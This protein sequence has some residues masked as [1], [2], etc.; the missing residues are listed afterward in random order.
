MNL[1]KYTLLTGITIS[2]SEKISVEA[3][4]KRTRRALETMLGF[5][6]SKSETNTNFYN[7]VGKSKLD[8]FCPNVST[9]NLLPP[10]EIVNSYRL[11]SYHKEDRY[12]FIDPFT[13]VNKVKLVFIR[14]GEPEESGITIKT[15]ADDEIR[16]QMGRDGIA[17]YLQHC[18]NY[19][20][21]CDNVCD[22]C[23]QLAVDAE[24][25]TQDC[26]PEDLLYVWADMVTYQMDCKKDIKSESIAGHSYS[27]FDRVL[28][29]TEPQNLAVIR[30]YAG[31][32]GTASVMPL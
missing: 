24:W 8:C 31:P 3:Q 10:D 29:E 23:V 16:T 5:T 19:F 1:N 27:K 9:S 12:F 6:L 21:Y 13:S 20:C 2:E 18:Q 25:M 28:P 32:Y 7:E 14:P 22:D 26:V 30:R 4:I 15:F 17:K 11:Y